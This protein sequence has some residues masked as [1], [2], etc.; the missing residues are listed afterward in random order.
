MSNND[1]Y[2]NVPNIDNQIED[3][4]R[5][6]VEKRQMAELG[7][8]FDGR[9]YRYKEYRYDNLSDALN[10]AQ[11]DRSRPTYR[12][13]PYTQSQHVEP[14]QPTDEEQRLMVELSITFDGKWY[15]YDDYRY[16]HFVDAIN[17]VQLKR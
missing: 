4:R 10:Y 5:R 12:A 11:L 15:R 16:D 9:Y 14:E 3:D 6:E 17:Y 13:E 1:P 8:A 7:V 2:D